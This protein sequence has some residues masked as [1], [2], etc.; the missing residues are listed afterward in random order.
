MKTRLHPFY[1]CLL[2]F[3]IG[4]AFYLGELSIIDHFLTL[5]DSL[6]GLLTKLDTLWY[7]GIVNHGYDRVSLLADHHANYVFFPALPLCVKAMALI[8]HLPPQLAGILFSNLCFFAS[9]LLFYY[10]LEQRTDTATARLGCLFLALSPYNI[11]FM[12]IYT[13]SLFLLLLL[14]SW[15]ALETKRWWL[16]GIAGFILTATRPNGLMILP[17]VAW[18]IYEDFAWKKIWR[19]LPVLLIPMG[20]IAYMVYLHFHTGSAFN[21]IYN[22][23]YWRGPGW[24]GQSFWPHLWMEVDSNPYGVVMLIMG[25]VFSGFLWKAGYKKEA[26]LIPALIAPALLSG[27]FMSL[28]R[29]SATAFSFY[30]ALALLGQKWE[31]HKEMLIFF[32]ILSLPLSTAWLLGWPM[33]Y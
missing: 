1:Y 8:T 19:Y 30:F 9:L 20:I 26:W 5:S 6:S 23:K 33:A 15:R 13:E 14:I 27:G 24:M 17:F 25:F 22:Q 28:A 32:L 3:I 11:Y 16:V 10:W 7:L 21:F 18:S 29:F 4:R 12:S 31:L 2:L